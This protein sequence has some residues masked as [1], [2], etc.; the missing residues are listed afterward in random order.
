MGERTVSLLPDNDKERKGLPILNMITGYFPK[1][2]REVTRVCVAN[3]TR[4]NPGRDPADIS[5]ARGKSPDQ[6][7]S[8]FRHILE[9]RVDGKVFEMVG[10]VDIYV[11]AEAAW[12]VL[13]ALELEIEAQE[14]IHSEGCPYPKAPCHCP[15]LRRQAQVEAM[16]AEAEKGREPLTPAQ[17]DYAT[18]AATS[19]LDR[20]DGPV[21]PLP[22]CSVTHE[23]PPIQGC[24]CTECTRKRHN[25]AT[26]V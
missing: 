12:R 19:Y 11:L 20:A 23:L 15:A 14:S 25:A 3:N 6:L 24:D 21:S 9:R 22:V 16:V 2:L 13:A 18:R 17:R 4:F 8:A 26:R 5:W 1:A 7:G 10:G